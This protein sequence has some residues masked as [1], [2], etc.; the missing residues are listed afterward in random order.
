LICVGCFDPA[1]ELCDDV[2]PKICKRCSPGL[3]VH[4]GVCTTGCPAGWRDNDAGTACVLFTINDIGILPFPFL[5]AAFL[6]CLIAM[7][8]K[9]KKTPGRTKYIST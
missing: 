5:C 1:C 7:F 3:F 8:G 6:G 9:C 2:D 4:K